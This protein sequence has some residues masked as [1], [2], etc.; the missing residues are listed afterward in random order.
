MHTQSKRSLWWLLQ[1]R[2]R[3]ENPLKQSATNIS[4]KLKRMEEEKVKSDRFQK[5]VQDE[6]AEK[7]VIWKACEASVCGCLRWSFPR[8]GL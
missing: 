7:G 4:L 8:R 6:G 1:I 2:R 3:Y 5:S